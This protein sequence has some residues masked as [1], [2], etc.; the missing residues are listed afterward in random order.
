MTRIDIMVIIMTV[1]CVLACFAI[2]TLKK[3]ICMLEFM[4]ETQLDI[5]KILIVEKEEENGDKEDADC[6]EKD[7]ECAEGTSYYNPTATG[8]EG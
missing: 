8:A 2:H 1:N 4:F 3:R 7:R 6:T 5:I